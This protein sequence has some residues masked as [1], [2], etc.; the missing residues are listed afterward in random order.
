MLLNHN[1]RANKKGFTLLEVLLAMAIIGMIMGVVM[2]I[3]S[4]SIGLSKSIVDSQSESR[5]KAAY[6]NYLH[7]VFQNIPSDGQITLEE[8][9]DGLVTL[10]IESPAT[11]FPSSARQHT[12]QMLWLTTLTDR[13]GLTAI[14]LELSNAKEDDTT[15]T[16]PRTFSCI[17]VDSLTSVRWELY[18][19]SREEWSPEWTSGMG[20]P[21]HAKL[22]YTEP[23]F[24]EEHSLIFWIPERKNPSG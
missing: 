9:Q 3:T 13:N 7:Q 12:A 20:R 18:N 10:S 19:K 5:H 11:H 14:K 2:T 4:S 16:N 21:T 22:Y 15:I 8:N 17:L 1:I 24:E 23:G 6:S